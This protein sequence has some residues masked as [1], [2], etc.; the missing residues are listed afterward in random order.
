MHEK[1]LSQIDLSKQINKPRNTIHNWIKF[2]RIPPADFALKIADILNIELRI[3]L[4]EEVYSSENNELNHIKM[5][6]NIDY[7]L[8]D[9]IKTLLKLDREN[10]LIVN[11]YIHGRIISEN[12]ISSEEKTS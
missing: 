5:Y 1:H 12:N 10:L 2:D 7:V 8:T 4:N 11:G 9:T 3:L 6:W